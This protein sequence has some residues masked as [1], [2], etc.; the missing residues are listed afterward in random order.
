MATQKIYIQNGTVINPNWKG[1]VAIS[2][3]GVRWNTFP[4]AGMEVRIYT[5][6]TQTIQPN[7]I[8]THK[9]DGD[10]IVLRNA[11]DQSIYIRFKYS[12]VLN[13]TWTS[14]TDAVV[15]LNTWIGEIYP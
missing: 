2:S 3:D 8:N 12:N 1:L 7:S 14:A 11:A 6:N 13:Q 5:L 10:F 4:K 9:E 15:A